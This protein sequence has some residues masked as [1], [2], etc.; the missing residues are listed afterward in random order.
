[1]PPNRGAG[2]QSKNSD[3]QCSNVG[4][5][6]AQEEAKKNGVEEKEIALIL[7][8]M[9]ILNG[10]GLNMSVSKMYFSISSSSATRD[11]EPSLK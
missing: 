11:K 1:M 3:S 4:H 9:E 6:C 2:T 10:W 7:E 5:T 8:Q